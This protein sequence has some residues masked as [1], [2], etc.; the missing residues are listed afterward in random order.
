MADHVAGTVAREAD[1]R[2]T[3]TPT[4]AILFPL[5][6]EARPF[7][8]R[9]GRAERA[10]RGRLTA[11][12]ATFHGNDLLIV[13]TGVG[14]Q[15]T[16]T[17]LEWLLARAPAGIVISAGFAGAL[18]AELEVGDVVAARDVVDEKLASIQ[19]TWRP[20][21]IRGG[22]VLTMARVIGDPAEKR[23]LNVRHQACAVDMESAVVGNWCAERGIRF[24]VIRAIT[25]D[26]ETSISPAVARLVSNER[27]SILSSLGGM[28]REP[29]QSLRELWRLRRNALVA[30][31]RLADTICGAIV[32]GVE[33]E[34]WGLVRKA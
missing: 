16:V 26:V 5:R 7:L 20:N 4:T 1:K 23:Q 28:A 12:R 30:G 27:G 10:G 11:W 32:S 15:R 17:A 13:R 6:L 2:V 33:R 31:E 14:R 24:G 34:A 19:T 22:R 29:G 3:R 25:D 18:G 8:K 21:G 9:L